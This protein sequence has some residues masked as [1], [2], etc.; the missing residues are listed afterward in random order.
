MGPFGIRNLVFWLF[1]IGIILIVFL[2]VISGNN[3][4]RLIEG[5]KSLLNELQFQ[6]EI[7]KIEVDILTIESDIRGA[8]ITQNVPL[9]KKTE[10]KISAVEKEL[11]A[12]RYP[13]EPK[14]STAIQ[15][16]NLLVEEKLKFSNDILSSYY[17]YGKDAAEKLINTNKGQQIRD[18][19]VAVISDLDNTRKKEL[20]QIFG[21]I[22]NT[23][24][25]ARMWGLIL[26]IVALLS[27]IIAFQYMLKKGM[28]QTKM[29]HALNTSEKKN[30]EAA[31]IK[32][33]FM[34]NMSH[35]I[36]TP[37]NAILGFTSLLKRTKLNEE[38]QEYVYNIHSSGENLLSLV[39]DILDLSK[40]EAGM[41]YLE[42]TRFSLR[43]L[44]NS[45]GAMFGEKIREKKLD[46][47]IDID[48]EVPDIL[49]GDAVRLTQ[50][51]VNLLS[52]A[53]KFTEDGSIQLKI[54][55][56]MVSDKKV[57]LKTSVYDTGIGI[58]P[59]KQK[60]IFER[61]QQAEA[62]TTRRYGGTGLGLA[63]VKQLVE[64]H[65]GSI[66]I[67]S[68]T[69]EGSEFI[70]ELEYKLPDVE[71]MYAEAVETSNESFSID[72]IK[73]LIAEDHPMNQQLIG[74]LMKSWSIEHKIVP[75]GKEVLKE[76]KQNSYSL[77]LMDIQMPEMDGYT[78]TSIL[79]NELNSDIPIIA[80]TAHAMSGEKEKCLQLGMNDYV[81][82]PVKET[83]LY[84]MIARHSQHVIP[85]E[86]KESHHAGINLDYLH[87]LSGND[88]EF[89]KQILQQFLVQTP[90]ELAHL[91]EAIQ[92]NDYA[93]VKKIAHSLKSTVGYIGLADR[94]HPVLERMENVNGTGLHQDLSIVKD[95]C[96]RA[97]QEVHDVLKQ[98]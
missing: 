3:I 17:I 81:S 57:R 78:A 90:V 34:A 82:K 9:L 36:R 14:S 85:H 25:R 97:L 43:S 27:V 41:M 58:A 80:M 42:E 33:Q 1:L 72:K 87:Q 98:G 8:V 62:E 70:L 55:P 66:E 45:V 48:K 24:K 15:Q 30:K 12:L 69:G 31:V 71:K 59:E 23:G 52:N 32:E 79:R 49:C 61:F 40:I 16:L 26:S 20:G 84:N 46:F 13:L 10:S 28:Q 93:A 29:I 60:K 39:N 95:H 96:K 37:M 54:D 21:S 75:N 7:R 94:L 11:R 47:K 89:E 18:S 91:E 6:N 5:N 65:K 64:L 56:V 67:K 22:E 76:I 86:L 50:I 35:E 38:Q 88:A 44:V 19:I 68:K 92:E 63:I 2:Q 4:N 74:H 51:M 83:I 53:V 73:V 77:I